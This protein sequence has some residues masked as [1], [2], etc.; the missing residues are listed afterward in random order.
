MRVCIMEDITKEVSGKH[1]F[2]NRLAKNFVKKG[3]K[4]VDNNSDVLLHIGRDYKNIKKINTKRIIMRVD[5]LILNTAMNYE[6]DNKKFLKYISK[7]DAVIYQGDF[8]KYAYENFLGVKKKNACIH[9]GA[10]PNEFL[11]RE[12]KNYYLTCCKWRPHK[13]LKTIC[14]GFIRACDKG[15]DSTLY[16]GGNVEEKDKIN[17]PKIKY[18]GWQSTEQMKK[19]FSEAI[20]SVHLCWLDWCPNS[21]VESIVAGCPIVY[22]DSG[23]SKEI[24]RLGGIAIKDVEWDLNPT[25]LYNPP[26]LDM[27]KIS[28]ALIHAKENKVPVHS[29]ELH[30]DKIADQYLKFFEEVLSCPKS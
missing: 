27:D 25:E 22:S 18:L 28:D 15:L 1:K 4:I 17:H 11:K 16:V 12:V 26:Q 7:S 19:F 20:A 10:D 29:E 8:C 9:N 13:R 5:G 6:K 24:G 23:G 2:L 21:M 30:I 14:E 3:I